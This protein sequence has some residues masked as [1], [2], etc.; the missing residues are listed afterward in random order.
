MSVEN[1][2]CK[3]VKIKGILQWT[4]PLPWPTFAAQLSGPNHTFLCNWDCLQMADKILHSRAELLS[5]IKKY[6]FSLY[7]SSEVLSSDQCAN[8]MDW[9]I[10]P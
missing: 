8:C 3:V 7:I 10:N 1:N 4:Y 9:W 6:I 5:R 2:I